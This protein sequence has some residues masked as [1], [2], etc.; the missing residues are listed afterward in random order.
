MPLSKY[1]NTKR[2][3]EEYLARQRPTLQRRGRVRFGAR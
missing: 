2:R 1:S 3:K